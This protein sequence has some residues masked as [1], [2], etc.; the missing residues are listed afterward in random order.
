[1]PDELTFW[2]PRDGS[3]AAQH[4]LAELLP[5]SWR[6]RA[7]ELSAASVSYSLG[8]SHPGAV[9][10]HNYPA[11][12]RDLHRAPAEPGEPGEHIDLAATDVLRDRERG[13][14]RYNELR[15]LLHRPPVRGFDEVTPDPE[16]AEELR[17]IYDG[18]VELID[19]MV[20]LLAETPPEGF[21]FSDTA[22]RVFI[23]MASRRLKNERFMTDDDT[24]ET[25]SDAGMA[26]INN[27]TF[28]TVLLRHY[29][30]LAP[31]L[32]GIDNPFQPWRPVIRA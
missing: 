23:V 3:L 18:D 16:L 27:T 24:T 12:L 15:R 5:A 6:E 17:R 32:E 21:T 2:S 9:T 14:P 11:F 13:V 8:L 20:G 29:P 1:M 30:A 28:K 31:A 19:L 25:Y 4:G 26:W 22:F 10:L 7:T